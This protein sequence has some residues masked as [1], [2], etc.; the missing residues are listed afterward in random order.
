[1]EQHH[2]DFEVADS[3]FFINP[4]FPHLGATPDGLVSCDC[5]GAGVIEVKCPHCLEEKDIPDLVDAPNFCLV[6]DATDS[7]LLRR[8]HQYYYQ[9]QTQMHVTQKAYCDFIVWG[10]KSV[11]IERVLPDGDFWNQC[12]NQAS[13][14]YFLGILPELLGRWY[15]RHPKPAAPKRPAIDLSGTYCYCRK[16]D[17]GEMLMCDSGMCKIKRFHVMCLGLKKIP[18]RKWLCPECRTL[19]KALKCR[20]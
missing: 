1:M 9:V 7:F 16:G 10:P 5:C 6:S 18:K 8:D 17:A 2:K 20:V 14:F 13:Q 4:A 3:G 15:T 12:V 11:H 19:T